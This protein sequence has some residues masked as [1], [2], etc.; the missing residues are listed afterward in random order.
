MQKGFALTILLAFLAAISLGILGYYLNN[1]QQIKKINSFEE[2]SKYFPVME[3]YPAQCNTSDGRH[4]VQELSEEEKEKLELTPGSLS[5]AE[6][7]N[8][9]TF[10][11][12]D[13]RFSI[14]YPPELKPEYD[15]LSSSPNITF[16]PGN[17]SLSEQILNKGFGVDITYVDQ[18]VTPEQY[19][20]NRL[21]DHAY[22]DPN[23]EQ[24]KVNGMSVVKVRE[25]RLDGHD[26]SYIIQTGEGLLIVQKIFFTDSY[27]E[28][29]LK[30][31]EFNKIFDL[32]LE[33][34]TLL[35]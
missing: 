33:S 34:F 27:I 25:M 31:T 21:A 22:R 9:K 28:G 12:K 6:I 13:G 10:T 24:L 2:C 18:K 7:V 35:K 3:S 11:S 30:Y 4:F 5:S 26:I 23:Y 29:E 32:M 20:K 1:Q 16:I 8:W 15:E 14:K 19:W 17:S